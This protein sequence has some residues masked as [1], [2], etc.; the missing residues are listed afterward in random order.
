MWKI[1]IG[2][3]VFVAAVY[4]WNASWLTPAQTGETRFIAHRGVHQNFDRTGLTSESCTATMIREPIVDEIENTIPAMQAA[5]AAGA[6]FVELDVH[7]TTDGKFAVF[8]D[9]TLDCR[10]EGTGETRSHPMSYLKTLD[11][12]YGY[13]ADG[14]RTFPL[15]GKGVGMMPE[16][17]EVLTAIPNGRFLV[18]FKS[19]E[20][21]E[22]DMLAAFVEANPQWADLIW[23]V[24]GGDAP[25][26]RAKELLPDTRAWSRKGL[27]SCLLQYEGYGWTGIVPPTCRDTMVMVP[28]NFAGW[29]WGWPNRFIQRMADAGSGVILIGPYNP[30]DPGTSGVDK[31]EEAAVVPPA[32]PGLVWTNE[33]ATI[34]PILRV[35]S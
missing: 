18:N 32:F 26:M 10:T 3:A 12:G 8:H 34:A 11:V 31:P 35:G 5:F 17:S 2:V 27:M 4:L 14:G 15:R 23:G 25:T 28:I 29:L 22:G 21:R 13:T 9:W 30:G 19:N 7:P 33:I 24:Y 16:L 1:L 6:D 20:A